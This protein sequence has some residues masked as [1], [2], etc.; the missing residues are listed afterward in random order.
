MMFKP[1]KSRNLLMRGRLANTI[2]FKIRGKEK[3]ILSDKPVK[4]LGEWFENTLKDTMRVKVE[5]GQTED[6]M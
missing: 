6:W 4:S 1:S 2:R 3:A 5:A